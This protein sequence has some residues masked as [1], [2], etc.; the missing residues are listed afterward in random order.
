MLENATGIRWLNKDIN[1]APLTNLLNL[2]LWR[3]ED[4]PE[5]SR[6]L[7]RTG[8]HLRTFVQTHSG[9]KRPR[10]RD[11]LR[12]AAAQEDLHV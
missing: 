2:L 12:L 4:D 1:G 6:A 3:I 5:A 8:H 11:W 7:N 9:A 10:A